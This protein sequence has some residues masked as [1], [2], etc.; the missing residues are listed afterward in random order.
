MLVEDITDQFG[1][2]QKNSGLFCLVLSEVWMKPPQSP[3]TGASWEAYFL[4]YAH[5][6]V[7]LWHLGKEIVLSAKIDSLVTEYFHLS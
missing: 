4:L 2:Q 5:I 7:T 1:F 3:G 6:L